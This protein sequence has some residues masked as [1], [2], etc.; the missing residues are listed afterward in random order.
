MFLAQPKSQKRCAAETA[1]RDWSEAVRELTHFRPTAVVIAPLLVMLLAMLACGSAEE[2][3]PTSAPVAATAVQQTAPQTAPATPTQPAAATPTSG[4]IAITAPAPTVAPAP[5]IA[6]AAPM[7][8]PS[9]PQPER[10]GIFV[11]KMAGIPTNWDILQGGGSGA[12]EYLAPVYS[13]LLQ[14]SPEDGVTI[15]PDLATSWDISNGG[16]TFTFNLRPDAMFSDG[17]PVTADDVKWT[18]ERIIDPPEG[19][20]TPRAGA[21]PELVE[22][23]DIVD[24]HTIAFNLT[25]SA[26]IFTAEVASGFHSIEPK[27]LLEGRLFG[28]PEDVIGSGPWKVKELDPDVFLDY[29]RNPLYHLDDRPYLDGVRHTVIAD[30]AAAVAA[31]E[32]GKVHITDQTFPETTRSEAEEVI[33][34]MGGKAILSEALPAAWILPYYVSLRR[35]PWDDINA[36]RAIHLAINRQAYTDLIEEGLG[37]PQGFFQ[38]G[39]LGGFSEEELLSRPGFRQ[40]KDD[41]IAEARRLLQEA[42]VPEGHQVN[43]LTPPAGGLYTKQCTLLADDLAAIGLDPQIESIA[44]GELGPRRIAGEFDFTCQ[45]TGALYL[46]TDSFISLLYLEKG[47][48]NWGPWTPTQE[49]LD[50]YLEERATLDTEKRGE[51]LVKMHE[52]LFDELPLLPGA[53]HMTWTMWSNEVNNYHWVPVPFYNNTKLEEVWLSR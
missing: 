12:S 29:E 14:W 45:A 30:P 40:P 39:W 6:P 44:W 38:V 10:G 24:D 34:G 26:A 42:G 15:L 37:G 48:R 19:M 22:S 36:R 32:A 23:M 7:P 51:L 31:F 9:G 53:Q 16:L 18:Y 20:V 11:R 43:V 33:A 17:Q 2:A 1:P 21:V 3:T 13:Q 46:D 41:D 47:G 4:P 5:T 49:F 8:T 27:H 25:Y 35:E 50:L 52:I 28:G